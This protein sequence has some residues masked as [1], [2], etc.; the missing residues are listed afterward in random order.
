MARTHTGLFRYLRGLVA[1][2]EAAEDAL[3]EVYTGVWRSAGSF[4]AQSTGRVWL[5]GIARRQAARSWRRRVGE[6]RALVPVEHLSRSLALTGD[7]S[8]AL[9][10]RRPVEDL[11]CAAGFGGSDPEQIV[12]ALE[13]HA[14]VQ[15]ALEQL[16]EADREVITL[17]D[18]EGLSGPETAALL[19]LDLAA[20]K[21]RLHR[22]R[23]RLLAHIQTRGG[24]DG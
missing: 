16:S 22:A 11:A 17:R 21:T 6:P 2:D 14:L 7:P 24:V 19:D 4:S 13:D 9:G 20:V 18:L 12:S 23:L 15:R 1:S 3:Q 8:D 5:Y 10:D